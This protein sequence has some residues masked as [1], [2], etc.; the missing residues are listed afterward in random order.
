MDVL[1][2]PRP[3]SVKERRER[4]RHEMVTAILTTSRAM[5]REQGVGALS[6]NEVAR[7]VGIRGPSLYEY[8]P[9][10]TAVYDA[11]FR[12]GTRLATGETERIREQYPPD[13]SRVEAWLTA[14]LAFA[15]ANP[16]LYQLTFERPV[17]GFVPSVE[18]REE[19]ARLTVVSHGA[20]Q[21]IIDAGV[22][23]GDIPFTPLFDF[24][25]LVLHGLM[26]THMANEPQRP[27]GSGRFGSLVPMA[28]SVLQAAWSADSTEQ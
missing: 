18:S 25:I 6:L 19:S 22:I 15:V 14:F 1:E 23:R 13:W 21:E 5:M 4:N 8:F 20:M 24:F 17:P 10:K 11:L 27:A 12:L 16:D 9:S 2:P 3:L 26:S 7:R 28:L